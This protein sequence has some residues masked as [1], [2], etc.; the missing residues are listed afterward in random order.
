[1]LGETSLRCLGKYLPAINQNNKDTSRAGNQLDLGRKFPLQLV[2]QPGGLRQIVSLRTIGND[3]LHELF[4]LFLL[5][6]N[7][8]C[9]SIHFFRVEP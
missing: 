5:L 3:N 2:S 1:M 8:L 7:S 9:D 4:S 6:D